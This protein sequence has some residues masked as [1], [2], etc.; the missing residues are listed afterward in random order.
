MVPWPKVKVQAFDAAYGSGVEYH[1][2]SFENRI[3]E[4]PETLS[5]HVRAKLTLALF[6]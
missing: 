5:L 2:P 3:W 1:V 4:Q 6:V